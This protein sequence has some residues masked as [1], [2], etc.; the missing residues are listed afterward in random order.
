[1]KKLDDV[2]IGDV[3]ANYYSPRE[4]SLFIVSEI[5]GE[6]TRTSVKIEMIAVSN[7]TIDEWKKEANVHPDM[8]W[9][10]MASLSVESGDTISIEDNIHNNNIQYIM[11]ES[12]K[13]VMSGDV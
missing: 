1:M 6:G 11:R 8:Y 13:K 12:I 7:M 2:K 3:L 9:F 5:K 10:D 4:W